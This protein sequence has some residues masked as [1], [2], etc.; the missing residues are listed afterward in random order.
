MLLKWLGNFDFNFF[1]IEFWFDEF[2]ILFLIADP[3][4][5]NPDPK[6]AGMT[7]AGRLHCSGN[8]LPEKPQQK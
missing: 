6:A 7:N 5:P 8:F 1:L 2:F 3:W 4:Q